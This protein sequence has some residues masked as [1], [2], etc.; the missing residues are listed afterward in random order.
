MAIVIVLGCAAAPAAPTSSP[1]AASSSAS[2]R[3]RS[4]AA[5]SQPP[6]APP[7]LSATSAIDVA[8]PPGA[9][10]V[11]VVANTKT[12]GAAYDPGTTAPLTVKAGTVTIDFINPAT[13]FMPHDIAIGPEIYAPWASSD[14]IDPKHSEVFTIQNLPAGRYAIWCT[15][16]GHAANGMAGTLIAQ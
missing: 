12:I 8:A 4:S 3:E 11:T 5:L 14:P 9:V 6:S 10:R 13:G 15:I 7:G 16:D 1:A 2:R